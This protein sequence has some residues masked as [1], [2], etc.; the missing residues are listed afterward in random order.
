MPITRS[1]RQ[2]L[3]TSPIDN[4]NGIVGWWTFDDGFATDVSGGNNN[5]ALI[6]T[7]PPYPSAS[8]IIGQGL[9]FDGTNSSI[10]VT[11]NANLNVGD[12]FTL[13]VWLK[14]GRTATV[15][16][17]F[18]KGNGCYAFAFKADDTIELGKDNVANIT[19]T[20]ITITDTVQFHHVAT[21][22]NG[23]SVRMYIDGVDVT[24]SVSNQTIVDTT[25]DLYFGRRVTGGGNRFKGVLDDPRIYNRALT[26]GEIVALYSCG[27]AGYALMPDEWEM[28]ALYSPVVIA[29]DA[30]S[31]SGYKTAQSSY[32]WNHTCSGSDR[33]LTVG[34]SMLSV[35]GSSVSS[36][37]YNGVALSLISAK[38][39]VSGAVRAELWG[40]IAPALGTNVISVTLSAGLDSIGE[41]VSFTQVN[42]TVPYEGAASASA[43]NVGAADATVNVSTTADN[44]WCVDIVAT[45]DTAITV[46]A[47]QTQ[48]NNV[49]GAL[50]SGGMSTEG[51][52]TPPGTVTMSWTNVGALATWSIV[53]VALR[54]IA[55]SGAAF[56]SRW[57]YDMPAGRRLVA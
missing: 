23:S 27:L 3:K 15:E 37:T 6:G 45:D 51:T 19:S 1:R 55:A 50:G 8:Q 49:S 21:T 39:S 40:L 42:Q 10:T 48:R 4:T 11:H 17:L 56:F 20:T 24:G 35:A 32:T 53:A 41:A 28:F 7:P 31:N 29:F 54:P 30:A 47:G 26:P 52:I 43:T 34:I 36:M 44:D 12:I 18:N 25:N 57:Y 22:K 5:G 46:G 14:R 33:Y 2:V 38:A 9:I 16:Q 13:S